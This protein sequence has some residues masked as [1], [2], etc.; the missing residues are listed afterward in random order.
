MLGRDVFKTLKLS[1]TLECF[2]FRK[3]K[4]FEGKHAQVTSNGIEFIMAHTPYKVQNIH[5]VSVQVGT[6]RF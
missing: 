5:I 6:I 2:L 1:Q 3:Y 4:T